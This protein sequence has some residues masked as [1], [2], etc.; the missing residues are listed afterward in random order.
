MQD[1]EIR[2]ELATRENDFG[3]LEKKAT[4][5]FNSIS[6][7]KHFSEQISGLSKKIDDQLSDIRKE[8]RE[9]VG[10]KVSKFWFIFIAGIVMTSMA[11]LFWLHK[12]LNRQMHNIDKSIHERIYG[13]EKEVQKQIH[14]LDKRIT[15]V[16]NKVS[17]S[18]SGINDR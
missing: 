11:G 10:K 14:S 7:H 13:M 16:E 1:K 6:I 12:D 17:N 5:E 15:K 9:A 2:S 18:V 3:K 4:K 8:L